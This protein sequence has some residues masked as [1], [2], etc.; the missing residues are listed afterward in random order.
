VLVILLGSVSQ[1][2]GKL[3]AIGVGSSMSPSAHPRQY[4][5]LGRA[6]QRSTPDHRPTVHD[7]PRTHQAQA[8]LS[9]L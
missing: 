9:G 8:A 7:C 1:D 6:L 4:G 2:F 3:G 5:C